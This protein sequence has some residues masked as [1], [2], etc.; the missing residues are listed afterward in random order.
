MTVVVP[1]VPETSADFSDHAPRGVRLRHRTERDFIAMPE[2]IVHVLQWAVTLP[3]VPSSS[4][5]PSD[6]HLAG[7]TSHSVG[8]VYLSFQTA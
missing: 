8:E 5:A 4:Y 7:S 6:E 3:Q 1:E 2:M